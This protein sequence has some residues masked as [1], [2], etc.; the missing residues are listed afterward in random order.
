MRQA[1]LPVR[2]LWAWEL[3]PGPGAGTGGRRSPLDIRFG[4]ALVVDGIRA[5]NQVTLR[6]N[7]VA[8]GSA[9]SYSEWSRFLPLLLEP[10]LEV[11][12]SVLLLE[13]GA[14]GLAGRYKLR[15]TRRIAFVDGAATKEV[16]KSKKLV[17]TMTSVRKGRSKATVGRKLK[18]GLPI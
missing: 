17:I 11:L 12:L 18:P 1:C 16:A 14:T 2:R 8:P 15:E 3:D 4:L 7:E 13:A 9:L 5:T 10:S 6:T